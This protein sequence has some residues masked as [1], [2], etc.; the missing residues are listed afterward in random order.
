L[1]KSLGRGAAG[2]DLPRDRTSDGESILPL[3]GQTGPLKRGALIWHFPHYRGR[4][5]VPYSIIRSGDWKLIKRYEG[6]PFELFN[7]K[8]DLGEA[9]DLAEKHP[10]K[11][12]TLH[13]RLQEY[14]K[15]IN[16]KLPRPNPN[17]SPKA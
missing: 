5:V 2:V 3:L 9:V 16:A 1:Q 14:L 13:A 12:K 10:E 17:Y 6:K 15:S 8:D 7:L 11:V 4:D